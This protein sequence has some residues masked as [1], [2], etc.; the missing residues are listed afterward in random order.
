MKRIF[1][2][3]ILFPALALVVFLTPWVANH[4]RIPRSIFEVFPYAYVFAPVPAWMSAG[5]DWM[6]EEKP[7]HIRLGLTMVAAAAFT[8]VTARV[9][10]FDMRF[11]GQFGFYALIGAIPAAICSLL[12][13]PTKV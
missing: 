2:F 8:I 6:L 4:A 13:N 5:V 3:T 1:I 7:L 12:S 10:G 9:T 11:V